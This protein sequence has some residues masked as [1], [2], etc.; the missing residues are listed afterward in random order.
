MVTSNTTAF[1]PDFLE[2]I[3]EAYEQA[4]M[5]L[6][7]GYQLTT[8]R[9]SMNLLTLEWANRGVHLWALDKGTVSLANGTTNYNLPTDTI[10][11]IQ[12]YVTVSNVTDYQLTRIDVGR[13]SNLSQKSTKSRPTQYYI[14]RVATPVL[15]LYPTP[16]QVYTLTYWRM[17]RLED[18]GKFSNTP[19]VHYRFLPAF[20]SGL[21]YHLARKNR[22][23]EVSL[24][25]IPDLKIEYDRQ[26][27][28]ATEEDRDRSSMR[29]VPRAVY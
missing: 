25:S 6:R 26:F 14:N 19:D 12:V 13:Y 2:I 5:E 15:Y 11:L 20:I 10:D 9:R 17:R 29:L 7:G 21:A 3:E 22:N 18:T 1:A 4:G 23:N 24:A 16:D 27:T 28:M 8:A